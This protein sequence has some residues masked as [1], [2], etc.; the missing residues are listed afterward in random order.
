MPGRIKSRARLVVAAAIC[1]FAGGAVAAGGASA[2]SNV[3]NAP[4]ATNH[5]TFLG[6]VNLKS[7]GR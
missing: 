4:R 7:I 5:L 3:V 2:A 6:T 1:A